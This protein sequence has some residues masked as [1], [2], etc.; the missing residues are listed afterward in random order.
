MG[1]FGPV[2]QHLNRLIHE[3]SEAC[4]ASPM[5]V[6]VLIKLMRSAYECVFTRSNKQKEFK[7]SGIWPPNPAAALTIPQPISASA[8]SKMVIVQ[9]LTRL[10]KK[11]RAEKQAGL[12]LEP[13]FLKRGFV[14]T[15]YG[16]NV[17]SQE[18]L[19]LCASRVQAHRA[20]KA[21]ETCKAAEKEEKERQ[22]FE[23][24]MKER[25]A[26]VRKR[27]DARICL[28]NVPNILPRSFSVRR[29]I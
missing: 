22:E 19:E 8:L 24:T 5:E 6:F 10:L 1:V 28:Y 3:A 23:K 4:A 20:K 7:K 17:T 15:T 26:L 29:A 12:N 14:N 25:L 27:L 11:R 9:E 16:S 18:D 2:K 21:R 13:V